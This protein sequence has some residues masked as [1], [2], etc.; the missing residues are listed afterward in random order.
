MFLPNIDVMEDHLLENE[1]AIIL[2]VFVH[3]INSITCL[4]DIFISA[5]PWRLFNFAYAIV[6]GAYYAILSLIYWGAGGVGIC[7]DTIE[8]LRIPLSA[9]VHKNNQWCNPFI[10]PIILDQ[11][12]LGL[13]AVGVIF[14]AFAIPLIH[15]F[16]MGLVLIRRYI[17][18]K[19]ISKEN[20][21]LPTSIEC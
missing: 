20:S 19:L 6:F 13:I 15:L 1:T 11:Q 3:G 16:W 21:S 5:R 14:G 12:N 9:A 4:I 8:D 17:H 18:S 10:Y 2:N 7:Y